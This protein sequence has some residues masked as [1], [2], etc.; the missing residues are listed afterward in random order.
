MSRTRRDLLVKI[1]EYIRRSDLPGGYHLTEIQLSDIFKVSRSPVRAA[2][3]VLTEENIVTSETNRGHYLSTEGVNLAESL[4]AKL[5][6]AKESLYDR[7]AFDRMRRLL[8]EQFTEAELMRRYNA[9][10]V[11]VVKTLTKMVRDG[12]IDQSMGNGWTFRA[13]LDSDE[14]YVASYRFRLL[15]EPS[16]L[17]EPTFRFD[18]DALERS[19]ELHNTMRS[20]VS[21]GESNALEIFQ[22]NSEFH[23]MLARFSGNAFIQHAVEQQNRLR[24][25]C[26]YFTHYDADQIAQLYDE[27]CAIMDALG[28]GDQ[29]NAAILLRQHLTNASTRGPL[30]A[31]EG[32]N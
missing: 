1:L 24:M 26:E 19:Q 10:R 3:K 7:I 9:T 29:E 30:L 27:H 12:L 16:G 6:P 28:S 20:R 25:I 15:I 2:L 17:L 22:I 18:R 23:E 21:R 32:A 8:P 31:A 14:L 13:V 11:Q 5:A 4:L